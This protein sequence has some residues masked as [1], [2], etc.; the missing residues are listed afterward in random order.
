MTTIIVLLILAGVTVATLTGKNGLLSKAATAKQRTEE[1]EQDEKDK[2]SS[3]ENELDNYTT[4]PRTGENGTVTISEDEYNRLKN[5]NTYL[6]TEEK[7]IGTWIDGSAVY[8]KNIDLGC[9]YQIYKDTVTEISASVLP[10][11]MDIALRSRFIIKNENSYESGNIP[12]EVWHASDGKWKYNSLD[13]WVATTTR[14]VYLYL[15]YTKTNN[16]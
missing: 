16:G 2:L 4:M 10:V 6:T 8:S 3:Y 12:C 14:H 13:R 7:E 11:N 5:I 9:S 1:A 15:E